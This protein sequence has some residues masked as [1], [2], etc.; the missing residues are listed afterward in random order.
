MGRL[1]LAETHGETDLV[2]VASVRVQAIGAEVRGLGERLDAI[3]V[4]KDR[5]RRRA[6]ARP[7][8]E[9]AAPKEAA[10][11]DVESRFRALEMRDDL[12]RLRRRAQEE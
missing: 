8:S 4:E 6:A 9:P 3:R 2:E 1:R 11:P 5:I 10:P 12:D 7:A